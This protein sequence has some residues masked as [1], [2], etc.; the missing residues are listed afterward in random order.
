MT[1]R[2]GAA[3]PDAVAH[4]TVDEVPERARHGCTRDLFTLGF[5]THI[6]PLALVTGAMA[7]QVF[8][9]PLWSGVLAV[10]VGQLLG[11]VFMAPHR[12]PGPRFGLPQLIR[13]RARSGS[14]GALPGV[15]LAAALYVTFFAVHLVL[16]GKS[17]HVLTPGLPVGAGILL[18]AAGSA[19]LC[20]IG[21]R[22]IHALNKVA[23]VVLGL[24]LVAGLALAVTHGL[25]GDFFTRGGFTFA[26]WLAIV[27]LS[28]L[29]QPALAPY[30]ADRS[31]ALP[32][33]VRTTATFWATYGG[34]C[35]GS[36]LPFLAGAAVAPACPGPDTGAGIGGAAG[37]FG[38]VLLVLFLFS[39]LHHNALNLYRAVQATLTIG[40][41]LRTHWQPRPR[42]RGAVSALVLACGPALALGLAGDFVTRFADLVLV[43]LA[44]LVPWAAINLV[45]FSLLRHGSQDPDELCD[46]DDAPYR[47]FDPVA[48][49]SYVLGIAVQI[50][51]LAGDLY[52]GPPAAH[53][54]GA[55]LSWLVE[56]AVT[57]P[58][59][60]LWARSRL[61]RCEGGAVLGMRE[62]AAR[63]LDP[64]RPLYPEDVRGFA[65]TR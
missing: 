63:I 11:G 60:F 29:W 5:G 53:F 20:L 25:P 45:D 34:A 28:A 61:R 31:R 35:L 50:P 12:A 37:S 49:G 44:A 2:H 51:F 6:A 39:V 9:Q 36:L 42:V 40:Q 26:G 55:D 48:L 22:L 57:A 59:Y 24:G 52:T 65:D 17:L 33:T 47:R 3:Q 43:L 7:V 13:S 14:L 27:S 62:Q 30:A 54:G 4:H 19:L 8:H 23:A 58:L 15:V 1:H 16:A 38:P 32:G 18:G 56:P 46:P 41:T 10:L 21:H 64:L